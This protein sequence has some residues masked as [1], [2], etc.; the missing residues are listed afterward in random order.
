MNPFANPA[1]AIVY[2]YVEFP[3]SETSTF[4]L[5]DFSQ[6]FSKEDSASSYKFVDFLN[7]KDMPQE[8]IIKVQLAVFQ[9]FK[10]VLLPAE[11]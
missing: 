9:N 1:E 8:T 6:E 4:K 3:K 5:A 10:D 11:A 2:E 7:L